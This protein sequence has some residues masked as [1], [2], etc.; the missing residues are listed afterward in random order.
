M[1]VLRRIP[2]I[3]AEIRMPS[4]EQITFNLRTK[5][6]NTVAVKQK[7]SPG[8]AAPAAIVKGAGRC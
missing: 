3:I 5:M 4:L 6:S 1:L 2:D 8:K 7:K